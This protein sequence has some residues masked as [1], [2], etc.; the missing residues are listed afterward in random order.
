MIYSLFDK[1]EVSMTD[2]PTDKI[3]KRGLRQAQIMAKLGR[4][5]QTNHKKY[6]G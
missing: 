1:E 3:N 4:H 2:W 6:V 5:T